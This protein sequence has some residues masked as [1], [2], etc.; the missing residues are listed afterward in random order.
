[1]PKERKK[2]KL[3]QEQVINISIIFL[4]YEILFFADEYQTF[5]EF[6]NHFLSIVTSLEEL[7]NKQGGGKKCSL[8]DFKF[9]KVL[10]KGSF[11]KVMLAEKLDTNEIYAIKVLKKDVIIQDDDVECTMTEKRIL[12]LSANHPF[13]TSLHSCFQTKD[14]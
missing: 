7:V 11:G 13:L 4:K 1:M 10:G 5:A 2:T 12:A 3:L 8:D 9:L 6:Y 14:R